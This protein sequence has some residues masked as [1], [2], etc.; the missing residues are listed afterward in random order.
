[1]QQNKF[2]Y[3]SHPYFFEIL[4]VKHLKWIALILRKPT[5]QHQGNN[6]KQFAPPSLS[7]DI[8]QA[9]TWQRLTTVG[10]SKRGEH[11]TQP[12]KIYWHWKL[13]TAWLILPTPG[14]ETD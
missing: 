9:I 3:R 12:A 11:E 2:M 1:M 13:P 10:Y 8:D 7:P 4:I 14:T 5:P 6:Y